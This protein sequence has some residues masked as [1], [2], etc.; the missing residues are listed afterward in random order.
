MSFLIWYEDDDGGGGYVLVRLISPETVIT[1]LDVFRTAKISSLQALML[2]IEGTAEIR[3]VTPNWDAMREDSAF[4]DGWED[5]GNWAQIPDDIAGSV[6]LFENGHTLV[7]AELLVMED[8]LR[9]RMRF[10]NV[11]A[12]AITGPVP[13]GEVRDL[14]AE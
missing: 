1:A 10:E 11:P 5:N 13:W 7:D 8:G 14:V 6:V 12:A 2:S 3:D 4:Q 9:V